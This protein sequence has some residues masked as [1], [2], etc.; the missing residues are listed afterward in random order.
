MTLNTCSADTSRV[1]SRPFRSEILVE[2]H[3]PDFQKAYDFYKILGFQLCWIEDRYMVLTRREHAICFYGGDE[4]IVDHGYFGQFSKDSKRGYAVE[5]IMFA[6][7]IQAL[8]SRVSSLVNIVAPIC[9]R[10]WGR[11]DFRI[12][13]PFG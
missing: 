8:Y 13:D 5:L 11:R 3:V 9:L 10:P 4:S 2:L 1:S 6:D 12:E 7:D